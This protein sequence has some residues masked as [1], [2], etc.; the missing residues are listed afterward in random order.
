[1]TLDRR[2]LAWSICVLTLLVVATTITLVV[3]NRASIGSIDQ[4]NP[5]EIVLPAAYAILGGLVASRQPRN[6][7]GWLF[8]AI[9]LLNAV[10]GT[11]LQYAR[12]SHITNPAAP[13]SPWIV[14]FGYL[15]SSIVY[16]AGL[17]TM[18]LL[19]LPNGKLLSPRWR[20]VA[21]AGI[22][23]TVV[24][25]LLAI[26]DPIGFALEGLPPIPNPTGIA[27]FA[28]A[29]SGTPGSV[30]FVLGLA[31]IGAAA[32]SVLIRLRRADREE[33]LQL[34][35]IAYSV[36]FAV[37][38]NIAFT[39][40]ALL[41]LPQPEVVALS[42]AFVIAGFGIAMPA[43]FAVAML[44]YRLYDLDLLLNRTILYGA[45]TA[46]LLVVFGVVNVVAQRAVVSLAGERSD[47]VAAALGLGAGLA[48]GPV[49]RWL[50]P[51]VDRALPA[52][53]RLTLL[54]TDIVESTQAV[55]DLGDERW[56][57]LLDRYRGAVR[58]ELSRH[59]GRE[60]NTAGDAFFAAFDRPANGLRCALAIRDAVGE[61]GLRV[62]TGL[63]AGDVEM[64]GEQVSGLAV[65]A[66]ARVMALAEA[67]EIV[68]SADL[69]ALLPPD[70][71]LRDA[72]RHALRGV[73]G[74]WQLYRVV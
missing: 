69:A 67:G 3:L 53:S 55:V 12:Y 45:V 15:V 36:M 73:P 28:G 21:W 22:V 4:A 47:L 26:L 48:F 35:W 2:S 24:L 60:V 7:V 70:T 41:F 61:L 32:L 20:V 71:P 16:P 10:P 62:R 54:F 29:N 13:F 5:I 9:A 34:R 19:R 18:V 27:A 58:A 33:R 23:L 72:G 50:R 1:M 51:V 52:R 57:E 56:R 17:A 65:H 66:A 44:R 46:V 11:T 40:V 31:V 63:H 68:I 74:E 6:A 64:R 42:T 14:W 25:V 49:R 39:V 30:A 43:G 8:L 59:R 38:L 37:A